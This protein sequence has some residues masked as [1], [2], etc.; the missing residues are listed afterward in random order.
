MFR[1]DWVQ[2]IGKDGQVSEASFGPHLNIIVGPSN[3]GKTMILKCIDYLLGS[4][5]PPFREG[6]Y[7]IEKV[8]MK[9]TTDDGYALLSRNIGAKTATIESHTRL[10]KSGNYGTEKANGAFNYGQMLMGLFGVDVTTMPTKIFR[11]ADAQTTSLSIRQIINTFIVK[12]NPIISPG[13]ILVPNNTNVTIVKAAL[14]YQLYGQNFITGKEKDP[15]WVKDKKSILKYMTAKIDDLK[16]KNDWLGMPIFDGYEDSLNEKAD[17]MVE[18]LDSEYTKIQEKYS[19]AVATFGE[20]G[21]KVSRL[22]NKLAEDDD[23]FQ[24]CTILKEQYEADVKRIRFNLEGKDRSAGISEPEH[25]PFCGGAM[26][27]EQEH[28]CLEASKNEIEALLPKISDLDNE[29]ASLSKEREGTLGEYNKAKEEY[30]KMDSFLNETY[31]PQVRSIKARMREYGKSIREAQEREIIRKDYEETEKTLSNI[32]EE[33]S[34]AITKFDPSEHLGNL[35]ESMGERLAK[36]LEACNFPNAQ[37]AAFDPNNFDIK[38]GDD[39]KSDFGKGFVA[40]LN[41]IFTYTLHIYLE[42]EARYKGCPFIIDSPI[43]SLKEIEKTRNE[44]KDKDLEA[45]LQMKKPLFE[46]FVEKSRS[47]QT[48]VIENEVPKDVKYD[49]DTVFIRFSKQVDDSIPYGFLVDQK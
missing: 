16:D 5:Q 45:A 9:V 4:L 15:D 10:V 3:C 22:S 13:K 37:A 17:G 18:D 30:D 33:L 24:K 47:T 1:I 27:A 41:S 25:C 19:E 14:L 8:Q 32:N 46:Y 7:P 11:T 43:M 28:D 34:Q 23:L 44:K 48:I 2:A 6:K 26:E 40:I 21:K 49:E 31:R 39:S 38:V 29:L 36:A 20:L 35:P 12:E 42:S